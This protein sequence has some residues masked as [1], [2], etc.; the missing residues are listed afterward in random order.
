MAAVSSTFVLLLGYN[1]ER[2]VYKRMELFRLPFELKQTLVSLVTLHHRQFFSFPATVAP[3]KCSILPLS[4]NQ[5]FVP[6]VKE[7]CKYDASCLIYFCF[8]S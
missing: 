5:E 4:Q 2:I 1:E 6:F 8:S 3:Y 7:L